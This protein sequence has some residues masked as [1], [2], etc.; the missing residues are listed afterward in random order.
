MDDRPRKVLPETFASLV[1][2]PARRFRK[3]QA[4]SGIVLLTAAAVALVWAN[5]SSGSYDKFW[6]TEIEIAA[7][8]S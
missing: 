5:V 8:T 6:G 4:S 1:V 3:L 7:G 2:G